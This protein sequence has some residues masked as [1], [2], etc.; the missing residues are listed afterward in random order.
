MYQTEPKKWLANELKRTGSYLR[1]RFTLASGKQSDTYLDCR[2]ITLSESLPFV[3]GMMT[4][5][6]S[7]HG[8]EP[9]RIGGMSSG[10]DPIIA[11]FIA[12]GWR[13]VR[14]FFTRKEQKT[15]GSGK[16]IEG[17]L[18]EGD[19]VIIVDDVATS[20]RSLIKSTQE[21]LG[22]GAQVLCAFV[23]VDREEGAA[24]ALSELNVPLLSLTTLREVKDILDPA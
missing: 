3:V 24:T 6:L 2:M 4:D 16:L 20:G 1:G 5:I 19:K 21:V 14:G 22:V 8:Y 10:A 17:H 7:Q 13:N 11:A 15:H 23:V 9:N 12:S 18:A